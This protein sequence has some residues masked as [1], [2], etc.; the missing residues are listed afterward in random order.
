MGLFDR[1]KSEKTPTQKTSAAVQVKK[2]TAPKIPQTAQD[3]C[4]LGLSNFYEERYQETLQC[5]DKAIEIDP[6]CHVAW[7]GKAVALK[8]LG[9]DEEE[10]KRCLRRG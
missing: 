3:W 4:D 2:G 9:T 7:R 8:F 10:V 1:F 5:Y 6:Q